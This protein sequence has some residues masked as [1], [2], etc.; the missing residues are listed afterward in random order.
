MHIQ[1]QNC[2]YVSP[3]ESSVSPDRVKLVFFMNG[4][5]LDNLKLVL[6]PRFSLIY[7]TCSIH[8]LMEFFNNLEEEKK[9]EKKS[10]ENQLC[11]RSLSEKDA[12][13]LLNLTLF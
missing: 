10:N 7:M 9:E 1:T 4:S 5:F 2:E 12:S 13:V 6:A 3:F 11:T 8:I